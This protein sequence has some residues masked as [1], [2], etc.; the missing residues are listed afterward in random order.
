MFYLV[1][2]IAILFIWIWIAFTIP[3]D[4]W[5]FDGQTNCIENSHTQ[6]SHG[7]HVKWNQLQNEDENG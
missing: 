2:F 1:L 3:W 4:I 7:T 5:V 6:T